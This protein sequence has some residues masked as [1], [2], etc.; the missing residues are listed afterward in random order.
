MRV[1]WTAAIAVAGVLDTSGALSADPSLCAPRAELLA[2]LSEGYREVPA[3]RGLSQS[4]KTM[5]EVLVS[6]D[7]ATWTMMLTTAKGAC[8]VF[9]GTDWTPVAALT[10]DP[11]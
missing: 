2:D 7:G 6:P 10:G 3:A 5:L 4:G 11:M 1:L 8:L 9:A